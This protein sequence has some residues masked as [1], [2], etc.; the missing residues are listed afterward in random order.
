MNN[1]LANGFRVLEH[2]AATAEPHSVKDL[3]AALNLPNSHACRLLKT[4]VETGY[5]EQ[6]SKSRRYV[7]SL[8]TLCLSNACLSRLAIRNRVRPFLDKL[9]REIERTVFLSVPLSW[10]PLVVDVLYPDGIN[11]DSAL[12]IG[13]V[14]PD[15]AGMKGPTRT[16]VRIS[17]MNTVNQVIARM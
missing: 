17:I 9:C 10:R 13:S 12:A 8:R 7:I 1:T 6:D 5:V 4:L 11:H 14:N 15:M 2:L 16:R 3:A